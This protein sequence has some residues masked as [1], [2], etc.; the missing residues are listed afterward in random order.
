M[1]VVERLVAAGAS[2]GTKDEEGLMPW[3][4]AQKSGHLEV[5]AYFP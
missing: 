1:V 4:K 5:I 2:L 3:Q